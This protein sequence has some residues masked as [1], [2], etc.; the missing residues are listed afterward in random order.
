[1]ADTW[2]LFGTSVGF[3]EYLDYLKLPQANDI[4]QQISYMRTAGETIRAS[5]VL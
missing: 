2:S 1:M 3:R 4:F 5:P